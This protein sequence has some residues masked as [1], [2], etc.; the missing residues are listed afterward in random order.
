MLVE[1][2]LLPRRERVGNAYK[3]AA[4]GLVICTVLGAIAIAVQLYLV[5]QDLAISRQELEQ[6]KQLQAV[7][8]KKLTQGNTGS[9]VKNLITA[10]QLTQLLPTSSVSIL[11][12]FSSLLPKRGFVLDYT[13]NGAT[14]STKVQFD[15][16]YEASAYLDQLYQSTWVESASTNGISAGGNAKDAN[17]NATGN[18]IATGYTATFEIKLNLMAIREAERKEP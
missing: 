14:V 9:A 10:V 7:E 12:Y 15:S 16:I 11:N 1:I 4:A 5:K 2:N 3:A 8:Q 18:A 17:A 13:Y 6:T